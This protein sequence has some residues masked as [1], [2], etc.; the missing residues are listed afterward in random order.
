MVIL[1]VVLKPHRA[2]IWTTSARPSESVMYYQ[3]LNGCP[4]IVVPVK[5]GAPL[6]AWDTLTLDHLWKVALPKEGDA[7]DG[8]AGFG[9]IVR[10]IYEYLDLCVDWERVVLSTQQD[11]TD[12][13][14]TDGDA[15]ADAETKK[16]ALKDALALL[17]AGAVRSG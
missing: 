4:A 17:V 13:S 11:G 7:L 3:L 10:T 15:K 14:V 9:G 1:L 16:K 12:A 6:L 8:T 2:G 5:L